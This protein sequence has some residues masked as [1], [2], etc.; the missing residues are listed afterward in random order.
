MHFQLNSQISWIP[1]GAGGVN[2]PSRFVSLRGKRASILLYQDLP[3]RMF[4]FWQFQLASGG[5]PRRAEGPVEE[6]DASGLE[7]GVHGTTWAQLVLAAT[8]RGSIQVSKR[9]WFSGAAVT[10]PNDLGGFHN[11]TVLS[12]G[13]RSW[14]SEMQMLAGL[15]PSEGHEGESVPGL[16][17][18]CWRLQAFL[19]L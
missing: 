2:Y 4:C 14:Q 17:L 19:G 13:S 3:W 9:Y 11:R 1:C 7:R 5:S 12:Y 10:K 18:G 8:C 6:K 15:V 16:C